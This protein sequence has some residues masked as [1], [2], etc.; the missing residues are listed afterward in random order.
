MAGTDPGNPDRCALSD[1][2]SDAVGPG[3]PRGY[4]IRR[5]CQPSLDA[6][7]ALIPASIHR[8]EATSFRAMREAAAG[9]SR[10]VDELRS[11]LADVALPVSSECQPSCGRHRE[12]GAHGAGDHIAPSWAR[13]SNAAVAPCGPPA[14]SSSQFH[15]LIKLEF[16]PAAFYFPLSYRNR[17]ERGILRS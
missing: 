6:R 14:S 4:G 13:T 7:D 3:R 11:A 10:T 8:K 5:G 2:A 12:A 1:L 15:H 17:R 9:E 16:R